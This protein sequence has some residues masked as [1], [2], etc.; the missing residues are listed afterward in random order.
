MKKPKRVE[1]GQWYV[2]RDSGVPFRVTRE[3]PDWNQRAWLTD[4]FD[5]LGSG[6]HPEPSEWMIE[7]LA[8]HLMACGGS[9]KEAEPLLF[10]DVRLHVMAVLNGI[11]SPFAN[12]ES[13][14]EATRNVLSLYRILRSLGKW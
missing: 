1:A 2:K 3:T 11:E 6:D 8:E 12:M 13:E 14:P 4:A 10:D 7:T 5:Y 9:S